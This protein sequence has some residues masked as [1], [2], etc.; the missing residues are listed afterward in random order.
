M[1]D[2]QFRRLD[3]ELERARGNGNTFPASVS[4]ETP[5]ERTFGWEILDHSPDAVDLSRARDGLPFLLYHD[6]EQPAGM[7]ENLRTDGTALRGDIRFFST[8]RGQEAKRMV[9]EG[10]RN[11]SVG[12][13][14]QD[15]AQE[16]SRGDVAVF[17]VTRWTPFE[18]SLAPVPADPTIGIGRSLNFRKGARI[19][20]QNTQRGDDARARQIIELGEGYARYLRPS[21]AAD[22][23]RNGTTVDQ[24]RE[25]VM[26]RMQSSHTQ[27][28]HRVLE[29]SEVNRYSL[30]RALLA[31]IT[32]DWSAAGLE[33][34]AS[35]NLARMYGMNPEGF[36][37]PHEVWK[38]DFNVGTSSE[39][40]NLVATI[41]RG[42]LFT[43][44]L[45][46]ELVL[47]RL[48]ARILPGLSGN[49]DIPRKSVKSTL[50]MLTEIGSASETN[51]NTQKVSLTPKRIGAYIEVSKQALIQSALA[52]ESMLR[53]DLL[54]GAAELIEDQALN[55]VG[56]GANMRGVRNTTGIGTSTAGAN[57]ATVAWSHI[58]DLETQCA[59][60]NASP[61]ALAGYI[62]NTKTRAKCK[63]V[64]RGTNL[65]E[66]LPPDAYVGADGMVRL[67]GYR[68]AFSNT[69]PSNLT[70]GTSTTVCS[71]ALYGSDWSMAVLALF[72][73]PDIVVDPYTL[74]ATGQVRVTLNQYADFGVRQPAAFSKI[75]DLLTA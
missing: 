60:S 64:A 49:I 24:F 33:R 69:L 20:E 68:A 42:D 52:L 19:M 15:M 59:N 27:A 39:A 9:Q 47:G 46:N 73:A 65:P 10:L 12:Y 63:Q 26:D 36:F 3:I 38:R 32:G 25:L 5:Y 29:P 57:G 4:S 35:R 53:D 1:R 13:F 51:P 54:M 23:V 34:D 70:K 74:A 14:I 30:G 48:G 66:I 7:V 56:T 31:Q 67:N 11:L 8:Q 44:A 6:A 41:M 71:A 17:R 2:P 22:A 40:G 50:G 43:D 28:S 37:V 62:L 58:V 16:G 55:G 75:E 72:G 61:N 21:D 45:R 18:V